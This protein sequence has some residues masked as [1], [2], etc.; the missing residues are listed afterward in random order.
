MCIGHVLDDCM[1]RE[2]KD[3]VVFGKY[4]LW[5]FIV[6]LNLLCLVGITIAPQNLYV[7]ISCLL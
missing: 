4:H 6:V 7:G 3:F 5:V 2:V 1:H